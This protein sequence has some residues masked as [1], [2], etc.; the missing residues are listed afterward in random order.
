[1][2]KIIATGIVVLGLSVGSL[3]AQSCCQAKAQKSCSTEQAKS[4][5]SEA[6]SEASAEKKDGEVK[7]VATEAKKSAARKTKAVA[8]V[9]K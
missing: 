1:M 2:K 9:K 3:S 6:K 8:E 7:V 5:G 4:C